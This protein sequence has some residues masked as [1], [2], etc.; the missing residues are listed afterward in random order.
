MSEK[1]LKNCS[2]SFV[3]R[4]MQIKTTLRFHPATIR[5]AKIKTSRDSQ[6]M[7]VRM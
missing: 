7:L 2:P 5:M 3:I 1:Y 4:K 6:H